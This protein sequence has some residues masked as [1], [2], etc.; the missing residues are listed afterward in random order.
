MKNEAT[1]NTISK[2]MAEVKNTL[3]V[4]YEIRELNGL[5]DPWNPI[6]KMDFLRLLNINFFLLPEIKEI[7]FVYNF[8]NKSYKNYFLN[9]NENLNEQYFCWFEDD[10]RRSIAKDEKSAIKLAEDKIEEIINS[11]LSKNK[12]IKERMKRNSLLDK[13]LMGF[14]VNK[15][16]EFI[17]KNK[18]AYKGNLDKFIDLKINYVSNDDEKVIKVPSFFKNVSVDDNFTIYAVRNGSII[19]IEGAYIY[20]AKVNKE[21]TALDIS[22]E[23]PDIYN[24]IYNFQFLSYDEQNDKFIFTMTHNI[25]G[26]LEEAKSEL[27]S[28][29]NQMKID[30]EKMEQNI[31][32]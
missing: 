17:F 6:H 7:D 19:P 25:Y 31:A 22:M 15:K 26:T 29:I 13:F 10:D 12:S 30:I 3:G 28:K 8:L 20:G 1:M 23:I 32:A 27:E 16:I 18:N 4:Y 9:I 2:T 21:K 5:S 11:V 24:N 14:D